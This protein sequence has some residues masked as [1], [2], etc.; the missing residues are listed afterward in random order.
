MAKNLLIKP[1]GKILK[2]NGAT[3]ELSPMNLALLMELEA[4]SPIDEDNVTLNLCQ[5]LYLFLKGN[6][7][8]IDSPQK[9]GEIITSMKDMGIAMELVTEIFIE[10]YGAE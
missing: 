1:K 10:F 8:E 7:P 3:Y 4:L 5:K 9:A 6:Y 2:L